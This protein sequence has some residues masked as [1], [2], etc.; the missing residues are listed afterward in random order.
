MNPY[1]R[2]TELPALTRAEADLID[3]YLSALKYLGRVNPALGESTYG[4]L[5]AAQALVSHATALRDALSTMDERGETTLHHKT[6][7]R[8]LRALDVDTFAARAGL[9][10]AND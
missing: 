2:D 4:A 1:G 9:P 3:S 7:A 6:L 5:V 8:A 10:H